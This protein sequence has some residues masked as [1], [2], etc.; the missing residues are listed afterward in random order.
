MI[1]KIKKYLPT[2]F[3]KTTHKVE[4][5]IKHDAF[6]DNPNDIETY[7]TDDIT[8]TLE[9]VFFG[10]LPA[11][12]KFYHN[13]LDEKND[14]TPRCR[15][16]V[17]KLKT[18]N[19]RIYVVVYPSD[20]VTVI[21]VIV[22]VALSVAVA[23][24]MPIP[25]IPN[26]NSSAPPSP[27]TAL[28]QRG[29]RQRLDGRIPDI[30]GQVWAYP[31]L[32]APVYSAYINH[33][34]V[35][36]SY[37]CLSRGE[38][39][40]EKVRDDKTP[41]E[42]I[43]GT[44]VE[45][46][47]PNNALSSTPFK[48][49]GSPLSND[50]K[51]YARLAVKRYTSVNGQELKPPDTYLQGSDLKV[52][53][54][55]PNIIKIVDG[56]YNPNN[57]FAVGDSINVSNANNI[58][59][60]TLAKHDH[61]NDP[62][63][64][65][66]VIYYNMDGNYVIS[67][68]PDNKTIVLNAPQ[69]SNAEWNKLI[70][71]LDTTNKCSPTLSKSSNELWQG[72]FFTD[73][74]FAQGV[75]FNLI[76][77]NGL[78]YTHPDGDKYAPLKI[79]VVVKIIN[80]DKNG[81]RIANTEQIVELD[82]TGR[83]SAE[84]ANGNDFNYSTENDI[85]RTAAKTHIIEKEG[86]HEFWIRRKTDTLKKDKHQVSQEVKIKDLYSFSRMTDADTT[87]PELTTMYVKTKATEGALAVK[88]R[89][90][91]VLCTRKVK[92]WQNND[93]LIKSKRADDI[94]YHIAT[95]PHIGGMTLDDIDMQQIRAETEI[96]KAYFSSD[97]ADE[98]CIEF[99]DTFDS[100]DLSAEETIATVEQAI[101][102]TAFR[103]NGKIRSHFERPLPASVA[104]F[105]SHNILPDSYK[106]AYSF[107]NIKDFEG[108]HVQ[109][110]SVVDDAQ[111]NLFAPDKRKKN[112]QKLKLKGVRNKKQA[113]AHMM[114]R[115][116]KIQ[117]TKKSIEFTGADES[118]IVIPTQQITVAEQTDASTQD[119][120]VVRFN[121]STKTLTLSEPVTLSGNDTIFIQTT[122]GIVENI[123]I[124]GI[125]SNNYEIVLAKAPT[126]SI[127]Q[128][129][130][131]N[132]V[133]ASYE[134]TSNNDNKIHDYIVTEKTPNEGFTNELTAVNYDE[135]YYAND[136][137]LIT[138]DRTENLIAE[139]LTVQA[140]KN[141]IFC[142]QTGH[143]A[144]EPD[145]DPIYKKIKKNMEEDGWIFENGEV[146][147]LQKEMDIWY[148]TSYGP[149]NREISP[150]IEQLVSY[151]A[152]PRPYSYSISDPAALFYAQTHVGTHRLAFKISNQNGVIEDGYG[153]LTVATSETG[154]M[155]KIYVTN[156]D[157]K[158]YIN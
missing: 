11:N 32:L 131:G 139:Q 122:A 67:S 128:R 136:K 53:F 39:E 158:S 123:G 102:C 65:E 62:N 74:S 6:S 4:L 146:Y 71:H 115:W 90:T 48:R 88:E 13:V 37:M 55:A 30:F 111:V 21:T 79:L 35:E 9:A 87:H 68:I 93:A 155:I 17:D 50:E 40:I 12:T 110:N 132:V 129:V 97:P 1:N 96:V 8:A 7:L 116:N 18:L 95:D 83:M 56:N 124:T 104:L 153:K 147:K 157:I 26:T 43:S 28:A 101:F 148:A 103:N 75:M 156:N 2:F 105:N 41:I 45:F 36:Y 51:S 89:K 5:I 80:V 99:C 44:T 52:Q 42:K 137:D 38:L 91:N 125:G 60:V 63:T 150:V 98:R 58:V 24:L 152:L 10:Q 120:E 151:N 20:P 69:N 154:R 46:F 61:D 31:D 106:P 113:H 118:N 117:H 29:N 144:C 134:I 107:G 16:D 81:N 57:F 100:V 33:T 142:G 59:S 127:S 119:G 3:G 84:L 23:L 76:A 27:N 82:I 78:Y 73:D 108:V 135:R 72:P 25:S 86:R 14:V 145:P 64:P 49:I 138:E 112:K 77:T 92:D 140:V 114:R 19:G 109:F 143:P 70:Q 130:D 66:E 126:E 149:R 47:A 54:Q 15:A 121:A 94:I 85:R 141:K 34:E 22:S 133:T